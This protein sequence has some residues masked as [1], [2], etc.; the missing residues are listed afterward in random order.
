MIRR[1]KVA[2]KQKQASDKD[3]LC[4]LTKIRDLA[5][6]KYMKDYSFENEM[7]IRYR[8]EFKTRLGKEV[9]IKVITRFFSDYEAFEIVEIR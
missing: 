8:V 7:C 1:L 6:E 4:E 2:I 9:A 3:L 5:L